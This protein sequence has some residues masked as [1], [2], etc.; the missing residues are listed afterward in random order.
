[1]RSVYKITNL[2]KKNQAKLNLSQSAIKKSV[3]QTL[4]CDIDG[5]ITNDISKVQQFESNVFM[6]INHG[7][8]CI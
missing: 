6:H 8:C 3:C 7:I 1:M 5:Y 4:N 2:Q